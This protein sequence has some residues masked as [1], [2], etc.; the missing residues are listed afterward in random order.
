M[1]ATPFLVPFASRFHVGSQL[2]LFH[3][4]PLKRV[5]TVMHSLHRILPCKQALLITSC[6]LCRFGILLSCIEMIP[7]SN[8]L[9]FFSRFRML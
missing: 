7:K 4:M 6:I 8:T 9:F 5:H 2:L 3:N 1:P